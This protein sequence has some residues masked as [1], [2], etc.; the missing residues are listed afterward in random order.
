MKYNPDIHHRQSI[1]LKGYDYSEM[2]AYFITICV[3]N[4]ICLLGNIE[5]GEMALNDAG[6][7]VEKWLCKIE[8]KFKDVFLDVCVIMPNHIHCIVVLGNFVGAD[9]RVCPY[10]NNDPDFMD[11]QFNK[12]RATNP[13]QGEHMGSP[14]QKIVQWLKT[15]TTNEYINNV[16]HNN[17]PPFNKKL[18]QRNYYEHIIRNRNELIQIRDY[19]IDNPSQWDNDEENPDNISEIS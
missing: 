11:K 18:W 10:S 8:Q 5:D 6:R 9:P 3:Q 15:M 16:K 12:L 17:W 19:I 7:L 1:R 4:H 13:K 2:G 14:L